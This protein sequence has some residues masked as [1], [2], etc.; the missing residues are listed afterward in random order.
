M[1]AELHK[2][3]F[4]KGKQRN[5]RKLSRVAD[6]FALLLKVE[7]NTVFSLSFPFQYRIIPRLEKKQNGDKKEQ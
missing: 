1:L 5:E 6:D 2:I 3:I 7:K 4:Y